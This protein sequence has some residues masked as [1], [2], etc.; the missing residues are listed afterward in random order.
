MQRALIRFLATKWWAVQSSETLNS[1]RE[2]IFEDTSVLSRR[3]SS[4]NFGFFWRTKCSDTIWR[5]RIQPA[6]A[7][8]AT[9]R[10]SVW[11]YAPSRLMLM[12]GDTVKT[13]WNRPHAAALRRLCWLIHS[14]GT[15]SL[16]FRLTSNELSLRR[17]LLRSHQN[18]SSL[19][20]I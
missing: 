15:L 1:Q 12:F 14:N 10:A 3:I 6:L 8:A 4:L 16:K 9:G 11:T 13:S 5:A 2:S 19:F 20:I 7:A 18:S 17:I